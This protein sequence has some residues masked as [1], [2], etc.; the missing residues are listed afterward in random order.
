MKLYSLKSILLLLICNLF[1]QQPI[2]K[3]Y[4][5][6][7]GFIGGAVNHI[8]TDQHNQI[9]I[10]TSNGVSI[11]DSKNFSNLNVNNLLPGAE[12]SY[13]MEDSNNNIWLGTSKGIIKIS[14]TEVDTF[15]FNLPGNRV[16]TGVEWNNQI[17]F[18]TNN[19]FEVFRFASEDLVI[20]MV[21]YEIQNVQSL[22]VDSTN[23]LWIGTDRGIWL[24]NVGQ[25]EE[26]VNLPQMNAD[27]KEI[28]EI[29]DTLR[30]HLTEG[31]TISIHL[32]D[33]SS[34]QEF[35]ENK[36]QTGSFNWGVAT[37]R[38]PKFGIISS[39]L[40]HI[41]LSQSNTLDGFHYSLP[42]SNIYSVFIDRSGNYWF[43]G[44]NTLHLITS[45]EIVMYPKSEIY[46][47]LDTVTVVQTIDSKIFAAGTG[48]TANCLVYFGN[49]WRVIDNCP[50]NITDIVHIPSYGWI[51][52]SR[53]VMSGKLNTESWKIEKLPE[54]GSIEKQIILFAENPYTQD[55]LILTE[56][57]LIYT[58]TADSQKY[59]VQAKSEITDIIFTNYNFFII[60]PNQIYRLDKEKYVLIP[61]K[62]FGNQ[63]IRDYTIN[64]NDEFYLLTDH[65]LYLLTSDIKLKKLDL[66][67]LNTGYFQALVPMEN[68][69][70]VISQTKIVNYHNGTS[71]I[72]NLSPELILDPKA[73]VIHNDLHILEK[74]REFRI[75]ERSENVIQNPLILTSKI[76]DGTQLNDGESIT[77]NNNSISFHFIIPDF[78][79]SEEIQ[80]E[81]RLIGSN[82]QSFTKTRENTIRYSNLPIGEYSFEVRKFTH[83]PQDLNT[84]YYLSFLIIDPLHQQELIILTSLGLG[85]IISLFVVV[86]IIRGRN[87]TKRIP[88]ASNIS[89][90]IFDNF[91]VKVNN[92]LI[93]EDQWKGKLTRKIL[94]FLILKS[95]NKETGVP[96]TEFESHFWRQG[97]EESIQNRKYVA[98]TRLKSALGLEKEKIIVK[99]D[100]LYILN[101]NGLNIKTDINEFS[102]LTKEFGDINDSKKHSRRLSNF[103]KAIQLYSNG[104]TS[105]FNEDWIEDIRIK[106][107]SKSREIALELLKFYI[108]KKNYRE[109]LWIS[110][111]M[112][113]W[114]YLDER[115]AQAEISAL[116]STG[117]YNIGKDRF[118]SFNNIFYNEVGEE[119]N[120]K[121]EKY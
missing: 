46:N 7:D 73:F 16:F 59:I 55:L 109:I 93:T 97:S 31:K 48:I 100:N 25:E 65:V 94:F 116:I 20:P 78:K 105:E 36:I 9:W 58:T 96:I 44:E 30:I 81:Y 28:Y 71:S 29:D 62:D 88:G 1:S 53:N 92:K 117:Q 51:L 40:Q 74:N 107:Q 22:F 98:L 50:E 102:E 63:V 43:G 49:S 108:E 80:Y 39:D 72:Y 23:R 66:L 3:Q 56:N 13:G 52:K 64:E 12:V 18:G 115:A 45:L 103:K 119:S 76:L 75:L 37:Y 34:N 60:G 85:V 33:I 26:Q 10:C 86:T 47:I 70:C 14:D 83:N 38:H 99:R 61:M 84:S 4:S 27:V 68:F 67:E 110:R 114:D 54:I 91:R 15:H 32:S 121:L 21:D 112:L 111:K 113:D 69:I 95:Y 77:I 87:K 35:I 2:V 104:I 89:V 42:F 106:F 82:D 6:H 120:L 11:F 8:F 17:W 5:M 57:E 24:M 90:K 41:Q 118:Q 79:N 101:W 19:G